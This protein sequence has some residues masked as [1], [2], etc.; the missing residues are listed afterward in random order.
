MGRPGV[1]MG[2][3]DVVEVGIMMIDAHRHRRRHR[4]IQMI[5]VVEE[6]RDILHHRLLL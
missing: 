5:T 4:I 6:D 2:H 3:A 1:T